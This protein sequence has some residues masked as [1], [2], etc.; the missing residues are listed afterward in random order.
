MMIWT[1]KSIAEVKKMISGRRVCLTWYVTAKLNY[2]IG[3]FFRQLNISSTQ[4]FWLKYACWGVLDM[5]Y[6]TNQQDRVHT[7]LVII[8]KATHG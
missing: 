2:G 8:V 4:K 3:F 6:E 5:K 7:I 1:M